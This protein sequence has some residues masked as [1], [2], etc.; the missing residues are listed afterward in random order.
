MPDIIPGK[1]IKL[2]VRVFDFNVSNMINNNLARNSFSEP[3]KI[4]CSGHML[5]RKTFRLVSNLNYFSKI[6]EKSLQG[7]LRSYIDKLL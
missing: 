3:S 6:Y 4:A 5:K 2:A 1:G 7:Q